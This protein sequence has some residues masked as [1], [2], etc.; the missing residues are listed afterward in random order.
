MSSRREQSYF[1]R[2]KK[3]QDNSKR[4]IRNARPRSKSRSGISGERSDEL[5]KNRVDKAWSLALKSCQDSK[6]LERQNATVKPMN[7]P[8]K[9]IRLFVSSTF[10]DFQVERDILVKKVF[11][12]LRAWCKGRKLHLVEIDLR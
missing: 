11:P 10:H 1:D 6:Y 2:L 12:D 4:Q 7:K 8:W 3:I 9:T 5:T